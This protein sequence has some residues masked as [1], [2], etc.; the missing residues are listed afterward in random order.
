MTGGFILLFLF[1][2]FRISDE[3][4]FLFH[5]EMCTFRLMIC[6]LVNHISVFELMRFHSEFYSEILLI[7]TILGYAC[8][9]LRIP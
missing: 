4:S 5:H 2:C 6:L 3:Y 7:M 1:G 8:C 9:I